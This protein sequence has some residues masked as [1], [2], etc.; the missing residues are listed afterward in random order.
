MAD[1]NRPDDTRPTRADADDVADAV[2]GVDT[3]IFRTIWDTVVH[4]PRV[5]QAAYEGDR[6]RYIPIIRMFLVLFGMQFAIMAFVGVP[7][8]M[9]TEMFM[10]QSAES[11]REVLTWLENEGLDQATVDQSL[12]RAASLTITLLTVLAALPY[13]L[14]FKAYRP[15]RSFYGHLLTYL[16]TTNASYLIMLPIF[17]MAVFGNFVLWYTISMVVGL[18]AYF[19]ATAR[20]FS[21]HYAQTV[22]GVV[23]KTLGVLA[24]M[25]L[26]FI[27]VGLGQFAVAELT[28]RIFHDTSFV[29]LFRTAAELQSS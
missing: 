16:L 27:I 21:T 9:T 7:T 2:I 26:T 5:L 24:L 29:D 19:V 25:P 6:E 17:A 13:L 12:E 8:A 3:R 22:S 11:E 28:L 4:T 10:G 1:S 18:T 20:V 23:F 15:K 14:V